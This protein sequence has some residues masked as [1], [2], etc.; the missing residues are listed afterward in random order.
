METKTYNNTNN[1]N[2]S[3]NAK[4]NLNSTDYSININITQDENDKFEELF[5]AI[6]SIP[7]SEGLLSSA[8]ELKE[9]VRIK[10]FKD[11]YFAFMSNAVNY[12][13]VLTPFIAFL[14][15]LMG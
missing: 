12:M 11:K 6:K 4:V 7:H 3:G 10:T 13:T 5:S 15:S 1:N 2:A 14:P 9:N 8:S